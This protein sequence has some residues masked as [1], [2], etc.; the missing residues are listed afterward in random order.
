[1]T[2]TPKPATPAIDLVASACVGDTVCLTTSSPGV[3]FFWIPPSGSMSDSSI[4]KTTANTVCVTQA[5]DW[6]VMVRDANGC[7]SDMSLPRT[8][9]FNPYPT[10][11]ITA[12]D[13]ACYGTFVTLMGT[14]LTGMS[15]AS[16]R[17][18]TSNP[19]GNPAAVPF[20]SVS[21]PLVGPL[22]PNGATGL[23]YYLE[24]DVNGCTHVDSQFIEIIYMLPPSITDFAMC[25][26]DVIPIG[27]GLGAQCASGTTTW[28]T[29]PTGGT[30]LSTGST[31]APTNAASLPTGTYE[32][33]VQCEGAWCNSPRSKVT[34][35]VNP[36]P[37]KPVIGQPM[38][39]CM[40]TSIT[41][42]TTA[43]ADSFSWIPPAGPAILTTTG[44]VSA[45]QAGNWTL[46]VYA[47]GCASPTS[48][49]VNVQFTPIPSAAITADTAICAGDTLMLAGTDLNGLTPVSYEW[50]SV[51][52]AATGATPFA[53]TQNVT[54]GPL[55][56]SMTYWLRVTHNGCSDVSAH[57]VNITTPNT[58]T[59]TDYWMC[60]GDVIPIGTGM[61]ALCA[62]QVM[63]WWSHPTGGSYLFTGDTYRPP[64][65]STLGTNTYVY[66]VQCEATNGCVSP[67]QR[68]RL[69]VWPKPAAPAIDPV[70]AA[71][72]GDTI[73][74]TTSA[75][76]DT[77]F[78]VPPSGSTS[79]NSI[80]KTT[81][82]T[83]CVTEGGDW[84][85]YISGGANFSCYSDMSAPVN[86]VFN[87]VPVAV[88]TGPGSICDGDVA[89]LNGSE[90]NGLTPAVFHWFAANPMMN[91]TT[92]IISASA[93]PTFGPLSAST[94]YWLRV[95]V[96][97][98][99][100]IT[101]VTVNVNPLGVPVATTGFTVCEGDDV[102][103]GSGL[104]A[105]CSMTG[106]SITWYDSPIGGNQVGTGS[107]FTPA[108]AST[109]G[110][111]THTWY[112]E[113]TTVDGCAGARMAATLTITG[114][115]ATPQIVNNGPG[116]P[117][118]SVVIST[119]VAAA[120]YIWTAPSGSTTT[121]T[122]PSLTVTAGG[123]WTLTVV[124]GSGCQSLA[125]VPTQVIFQGPATPILTKSPLNDL[126]EG[127]AL[128]LNVNSYS[129][130]SVSYN[131][132]TP[133]GMVSTTVP[134]LIINPVTAANSGVYTVSVS[135]DTCSSP[136]SNAVNV[137]VH[138]TPTT[139]V[140][141]NNG[142]VCEGDAI[143]LTTGFVAGAT[144]MWSGPNGFSSTVQNPTIP[145]ATMLDAGTY[146]LT[147]NSG[148]CGSASTTTVVSVS[149]KPAKPVIGQPTTACAG[150]T[151]V[152]STIAS[153]DT[154]FWIPPSGGH[155]WTLSGSINVTQGGSWSLYVKN[156]TG[157]ISDIS[158]PV[159]VMFTANPS[160]AITA[161]TT[162][163]VGDTAQLV[164]TDLNS[165]SPV[166]YEWFAMNPTASGAT[167]FAF[168]QS[169]SVGP[170]STTTTYWLR[171]THNG[172]SDITSHTISTAVANT[173][174]VTDYI[175]C[176]GDV[177]PL[178]TGMKAQC[179]GQV[180]TWWTQ[181]TG[182]TYLITGDT[183]RP[184]NA[185][186]FLT[187]TYVYWVQCEAANGCVSPR[188]R[189]R[190][191][192]HPKPLTPAIQP[193]ST[194]AC[195]GD[196]IC[197]TTSAIA[198][199]F[200][201][202]PPS[203][204]LS[205]SSIQKTTVNTLCV[206]EGGDWSVYILGGANFACKSDISAPVNVVF[207][208]VPV[209]VATGPSAVCAGDMATLN[210][211]ELNGLTPAVYHWF[212]MDPVMNPGAPIVST[213]Q[214]PV[215]GPIT[216]T[217][218][219]WLR[220]TV[221][222]CEGVT[223]ITINVNP[224]TAPASTTG[225][226]VCEGENVPI[227]SGL[228]ATC[229]TTGS[230]ITWYDAPVGGNV[231]GTGG[232]YTPSNTAALAAGV[233]TWYA[234]CTTPSGCTG[235][236]ASVNLTVTPKPAT[237]QIVNN[238]PGCVGDSVD[239]STGVMS[240]LY[241][242][243]APSGATYVTTNSTL[244][245]SQAGNWTVQVV[246]AAGC[247]SDPSVPTMVSF[248]NVLTPTITSSASGPLCEGD[249]LTLNATA[250]TGSNVTYTWTTPSG[251]IVTNTPT[252]ILNP[253]TA[254]NTGNY[255]VAVTVGS[256][257]SLS[258]N[259]VFVQVTAT[260]SA[261]IA[262]SN[263]PVCEGDAILLTTPNI[264]GA[265]FM[266]SGPNGFV[267]TLRNPTIPNATALNAG[268][269]VVVVTINGCSSAASAPA[270][271]VVNPKPAQPLITNNGPG[272]PGDSVDVITGAV[273]AQYIW[274]GPTGATYNTTTGILRVN[275][276][277]TW[278][279]Q[280]VNA[281][282][283]TSFASTPTVVTFT[284]VAV[285]TIST[286]AT[287][288][289][290]EGDP[291]TISVAPSYGGAVSYNW[292]TPA[293]PVSTAVPTLFIGSV[294][295]ANSGVYSVSVS[296]NG[297]ASN[298]SN[299][300]TII[301]TPTPATP[302]AM[303]NTPVCAGDPILLSTPAIA[304]ATYLWSGPNGFSSTARDPII[305]VAS[306]LDTGNYFV[307]VSINGCASAVS[308]ATVVQVDPLPAVPVVTNN[309][310]VCV[311]GTITLSVVGPSAGTTYE[312][313]KT[314]TGLNIGVGSIVN[315]SPAAVTDAGNYYAIARIGNCV[316]AASSATLVTVD[317]ATL[318]VAFAGPN[319]ALCDEPF[320]NLNA[321]AP[322]QGSGMWSTASS[323]VIVN[324]TDP[325]SSVTGLVGGSSYTFTWTIS[326]GVCGNLSSDDVTV[327]VTPTS[328]DIAE[329]GANQTL[330]EMTMAN[331][332]ATAPTTSVGVWTQSAAQSA[333][334]V[335]IAN[336]SMANTSVSGLQSGGTYTF[337][338][339]L[340]NGA[341]GVIG[342][343]EVNITIIPGS[344][345]TPFAGS[346]QFI[347]D[348]V[349]TLGAASVGVGMGTWT[350]GS[351]NSPATTVTS[352]NDPQTFVTDLQVGVNTFIWTVTNG[353][354][355][356][357]GSDTVSVI[358]EEAPVAVNDN[359]VTDLNEE[360]VGFDVLSNDGLANVSGVDVYV[361]SQPSNGTLLDDGTGTYTYVPNT[362]F[363]GVDSFSYEIC[364]QTC[365]DVCSMATVFIAVNGSLIC[366]VPNIITPNNDG[367]N[368]VLFIPCLS[369]TAYPNSTL[370]ILNRW[371]DEVYNASP[372]N[373]DWNGTYNGS[374]LPEGTY[375]YILDLGDGSGA[376]TGYVVIHL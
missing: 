284:G 187:N 140:A 208:P 202:V 17:W 237:P 322:A 67:R 180:M 106:S 350:Q 182:G 50:F 45:S 59:V 12:P 192:V 337:T 370:M 306:L 169:I 148:G 56:S 162:V 66:W 251:T 29:Q 44:S 353:V 318:N 135:V 21:N 18:F 128:T 364:S 111:G 151:I 72:V 104:T 341:C 89:S 141:S 224:A 43:A 127:D 303:N 242:W 332:S 197:L 211:S 32:Y 108:N 203:G 10:A 229:V 175:M 167:P 95:T 74:L 4:I 40:G 136:V 154:F 198:D 195:E 118:G 93:N 119:G 277:G 330:C 168:L 328:T 240:T 199:T 352:P 133:T 14:E 317:S 150:G 86:V 174:V 54:V 313:Y 113:C 342:T 250:Y 105:A 356:V 171:I 31:Y 210:G 126:C 263:S 368:D 8:V 107:V 188:A 315:I 53:F 129:G 327:S 172:C 176:E 117:G 340:S 214:N 116:C 196:T 266:W 80:Q 39:A 181:P 283:C 75:S 5:G 142:P 365:D 355:G 36:I 262:A 331:L 139:P 170:I 272:C 179:G 360:I 354:C 241:T 247:I 25:E 130:T 158:D 35:T 346:T 245:V 334:G 143:T 115:P 239:I 191:V 264:P 280:V 173:P 6:K 11:V 52:P 132:T 287:S 9:V 221:N 253:V 137:L 228:T 1:L 23:W 226:T 220:V 257:T 371:G 338:W 134:T 94:T 248:T 201:W 102:P 205:Y 19:M 274:T 314:S 184:P 20:A 28:W 22:Y 323:A 288:P 308:A 183:Y 213:A 316:S 292:T 299:A 259:T 275:Q 219:R 147:I 326:N 100:D 70:A 345:E 376:M 270:N 329:A 301:V 46:V 218:T 131:W 204:S 91:P 101:S 372:Y 65:A 227:G 96:N 347:C 359:Y 90:L 200:Y 194:T 60:E 321:T 273:A 309:S 206:T 15:P 99:S 311:G 361:V 358:V 268:A 290:C 289:I 87:P 351:G 30:Y 7:L 42:T 124:D 296:V 85:L 244:R 163:C 285:P 233:Y 177:I 73:C 146:F 41:L 98:C 373:N 276:A 286:T 348:E 27:S 243:T 319:Q 362:N 305:P 24:V 110:A 47:G 61:E 164:G 57:S 265:T 58:P 97:G 320:T 159:N 349:A 114:R 166:S 157:C 269:Y 339:E 307:T 295:A 258:S 333:A 13:T 88:A 300:I 278:S 63:T 298:V 249:V 103:I 145:S 207:N 51:N 161:P 297:C 68:V 138:P 312:W 366:D 112:A 144:Y 279:V 152:L 186:T 55:S 293:G 222:G 304:G 291:L 76:A 125:S 92:P 69:I 324:P 38:V 281:A 216:A 190:L 235:S 84:T 189:V 160:A 149:P 122:T 120:Q 260:P 81:T 109:L 71:C 79:Y 64:N 254:S 82:N 178:G 121:T 246:N 261:P 236:R 185:N 83:L 165:L 357:V 234:E 294:T 255:S 271:V 78:W 153:A 193:P 209:A 238:G 37:G 215:M 123:L 252:L 225:F 217:T 26:G 49:P 212:A 310:P 2:I 16:Y 156:A 343:D 155:L 344:N 230:S 363:I 232:L 282:G 231:V 367:Y 34:L 256:C 267:S 302:M 325:N 77:F 375:F 223:S 48:D 33:W 369:G 335:A 374:P 3:E 62:G 336:P